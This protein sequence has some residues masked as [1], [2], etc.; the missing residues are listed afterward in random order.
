MLSHHRRRSDW[1]EGK[2]ET[3]SHGRYAGSDFG[4]LQEFI[5]MYIE[6]GAECTNCPFTTPIQILINPPSLIRTPM[7]PSIFRSIQV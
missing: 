3:N 6:R 4:R 1:R 2:L 5:M 7:C